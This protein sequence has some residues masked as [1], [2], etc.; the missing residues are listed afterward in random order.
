MRAWPTPPVGWEADLRIARGLDYY[1]GTVYETF[2]LGHPEFG[3]VCSGGR[4]DELAS[5]GVRAY[6][7]VGVSIGVT[8][9]MG[10]IVSRGL[11]TASRS[12]PAAVLVAVNDEA[13]RPL[14]ERRRGRTARPGVACEVAPR[15]PSSANRSGMPTAAASRSCGS[16]PGTPRPSTRSRTSARGAAAGRRADVVTSGG[17][18]VPYGDRG[19]PRR[20]L[21]RRSPRWPRMVS[22]ASRRSRTALVGRPAR[23]R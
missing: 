4:Y 5:D 10:L 8:R 12:T 23:G 9:L 21:Q 17:G 3:A 15:R 20:G 6:P 18:P 22:A 16:P 13:S 14:L 11:A 19:S 1:T 2:L 7:G